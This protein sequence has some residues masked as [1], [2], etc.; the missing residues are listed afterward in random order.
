M[1][2]SERYAISPDIL[3]YYERIGLIPP[4]HRNSSGIHDYDEL[5]LKRVDFIKFMR[6]A[7]LPVETLIEYMNL[8]KQGDKTVPAR[9]EILKEQRGQVSIRLQELYKTLDLLDRKIKD[10]DRILLDREQDL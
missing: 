3:R 1:E 7:G 10:Y 5:D 9:K 2:V 8:V 4:V 6:G